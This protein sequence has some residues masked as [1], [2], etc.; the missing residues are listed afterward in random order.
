MIYKVYNKII[1]KITI[2]MKFKITFRIA[3]KSREYQEA[4]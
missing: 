4:H 3:T 1:N 2:I